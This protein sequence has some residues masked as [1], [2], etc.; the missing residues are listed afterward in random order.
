MDHIYPIQ[1]WG[2]VVY[3]CLG[4]VRTFFEINE[5]NSTLEPMNFQYLIDYQIIYSIFFVI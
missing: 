3:F 2:I 1:V 5:S 4:F